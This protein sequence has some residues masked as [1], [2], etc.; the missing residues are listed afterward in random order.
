MKTE[1]CIITQE[2]M[3]NVHMFY[4]MIF[5]VERNMNNLQYRVYA[6]QLSTDSEDIE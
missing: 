2:N 1:C 6:F 3:Y 5:I 4:D